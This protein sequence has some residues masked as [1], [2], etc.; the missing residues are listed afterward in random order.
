MGTM[1]L[2]LVDSR[3]GWTSALLGRSEE[4]TTTYIFLNFCRPDGRVGPET[5]E[6]REELALRCAGVTDQ[7]K[8]ATQLHIL[9][10]LYEETMAKCYPKDF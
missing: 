7:A 10:E 8:V 3:G 1:I 2:K 4:R 5:V 9:T 6:T